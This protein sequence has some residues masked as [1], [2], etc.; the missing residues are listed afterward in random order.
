[1]ADFI[2]VNSDLHLHGLYSGAVSAD[3]VPKKIGEQAPLKGLQLLG[4][5]DILN[6]RWMKLIR[7][8]L[9]PVGGVGGGDSIFEHGNG[10]KFILQT[11]VEDNTRVHHI[12][13]FPSFSKVEEVRERLKDK[14]KDLDTEGR[15]KIHASAEEL[16]EICISAGCMIGPSHAF[17]PWTAIFKEF[18]S[19]KD[20]Y[21][22]YANE[23]HFLELGLSADTNMA[24]KISELHRLT[25]LSNSD[26]HSP[27]PNKM[28][29][30]F[31]TLLLQE[32]S[33]D[34]VAKAL[35]REGGRKCVLNV[36]LNPAEGKYH[37]TRCMNCLTFFNRKDAE[38]YKWRCP[39]CRSSIKKGVYERID[40]LADLPEGKHP[41]HR[42]TYIYTIPLSEIIALAL[43]VK[44]V[45]SDR[46]QILWSKFIERFG[47]EINALIHAPPQELEKVHAKTA[48]LIIAFRENR[49]RYVPGG[50]G[51]YGIPIPP[52]KQMEMKIWS[53]GRVQ[54]ITDIKEEKESGQKS[55]DE[56][57]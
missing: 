13:L 2:E 7:E 21:G 22:K 15:P 39:S 36:G 23:I 17:T 25:F 19:V 49:F 20:C 11:E 45:Y 37:K 55:L 51:A 24:D 3:M 29:R 44:Q 1:M 56:Y 41:E 34:E 6:A 30:E 53:N 47:S 46:V 38:V 28:G 14:C 32:I 26:A 33:F 5:A 31:N 42:P 48:E 18:N 54:T 10:T 8:Q 27:W 9:L 35:K 4:T 50:A 40:E 57:F 43:D 16:A 12:I 52:G